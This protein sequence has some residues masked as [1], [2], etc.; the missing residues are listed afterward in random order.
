MGTMSPVRLAVAL[1]CACL[2]AAPRFVTSA[3]GGKGL[4]H[5]KCYEL[6]VNDLFPWTAN[7]HAHDPLTLTPAA[8]SSFAKESGCQLLPTDNPR[9]FQACVRVS[10]T[11]QEP[12]TGQSLLND[13]LCFRALC[14]AEAEDTQ[15]PAADN[16][17][18]EGQP[19]AK[20][21]T[22]VRILCVPSGNL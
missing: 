22:T 21:T 6:V 8:I 13:F 5:L 4:D 18:G 2:V 15:L 14:P 1:A 20:R 10:K 7:A 3:Y 11:P 9:P 16:Q 17:F 19:L 12:P